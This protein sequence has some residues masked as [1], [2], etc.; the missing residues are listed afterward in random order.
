MAPFTT[1]ISRRKESLPTPANIVVAGTFQF[2]EEDYKICLS[3]K[4]TLPPKVEV[5]DQMQKK[6]AKACVV[7]FWFVR[8]TT[9]ESESNAKVDRREI[10]VSASQHNKGNLARRNLIVPCIVNAKK[11]KEGCEVVLLEGEDPE[12]APAAKR[13]KKAGGH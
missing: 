13:P 7:P 4:T 5:A 11:I 10:I 1:I 3:P 12:P 2:M 6:V 8:S 9:T